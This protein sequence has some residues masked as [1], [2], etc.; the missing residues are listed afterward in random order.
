MLDYYW[1]RSRSGSA[2]LVR[3]SDGKSAVAR[4]TRAKIFLKVLSR[5]CRRNHYCG[6]A[7]VTDCT[8]PTAHIPERYIMVT[9][10]MI[11]IF[12]YIYFFSPSVYN[13][14]PSKRLILLK[15]FVCVCVCV[16]MGPR[17][18][19]DSQL[20][21]IRRVTRVA[22]TGWLVRL[23]Q[24]SNYL[25]WLISYLGDTDEIKKQLN[26]LIAMEIK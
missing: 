13:W 17:M 1:G 5:T 19:K 6:Y 12:I 9:A 26:L 18:V 21:L 4:I 23:Q 25:Y 14:T 20:D 22:D 8:P 15:Y 11:L 10:T 24:R 7:A 3:H 2:Y 16:W